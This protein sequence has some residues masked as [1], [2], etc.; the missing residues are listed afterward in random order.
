M[1]QANHAGEG[2]DLVLLSKT[3][4]LFL[5]SLFKVFLFLGS[6]CS[7]SLLVI[8]HAVDKFVLDG[9]LTM[10]ISQMRMWDC[11]QQRNGKMLILIWTDINWD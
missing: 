8:V 7:K 11:R 1:C 2:Q 6:D 9:C 5:N 3:S 10:H 4:L